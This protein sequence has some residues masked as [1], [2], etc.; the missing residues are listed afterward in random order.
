MKYFILLF[1][2]TFF[3]AYAQEIDMP[4]YFNINDSILKENNVYSFDNIFLIER[5]VKKKDKDCLLNIQIRNS[6]DEL[7]ISDSLDYYFVRYDYKIKN[8]GRFSLES[9]LCINKYTNIL[10]NVY[11]EP[12]SYILFRNTK[13]EQWSEHTFN[14]D[15]IFSIIESRGEVIFKSKET[16][17]FSIIVD[18]FCKD[19][20]FLK[21]HYSKRIPY[22]FSLILSY[23]D[24]NDIK[25]T[26]LSTSYSEE[27]DCSYNYSSLD[28]LNG[29]EGIDLNFKF[30]TEPQ[31]FVPNKK[32]RCKNKID[33]D[34]FRFHQIVLN[35]SDH[36]VLS[37]GLFSNPSGAEH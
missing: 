15:K 9:I 25:E 32:K 26:I 12:N 11:F 34:V 6:Y 2:F 23:Q 8:F 20:F 19:V 5:S 29:M 22:T 37:D 13:K 3:S 24:N 16:N 14:L 10:D 33:Y 31:Y 17:K 7:L 21:A 36:V 4:F 18:G 28:R 1:S 35:F 30:E 27:E